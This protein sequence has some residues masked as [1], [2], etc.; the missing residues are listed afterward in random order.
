MSF[1]LRNNTPAL[2]DTGDPENPKIVGANPTGQAL[3]RFLGADLAK[4]DDVK[5]KVNIPFNSTYKFSATQVE[6]SQNL[7]MVK[8]GGRN[9]A[10]R[11]YTLFGCGR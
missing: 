4:H 1:A 11:M 10:R 5:V 8:G 9:R 3:L 6:G 2:I 7:T